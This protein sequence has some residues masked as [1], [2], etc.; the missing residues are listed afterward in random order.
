MPV[1]QFDDIPQIRRLGRRLLPE[2]VRSGLGHDHFGLEPHP[3]GRPLTDMMQQRSDVPGPAGFVP[4]G[5][6]RVHER[7]VGERA[8]ESDGVEQIRLAHSVRAGDA[9][10][11]AE[12]DIHG[13]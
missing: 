12:V 8:Q 3:V 4:N 7:P 13:Y 5:L 10:E 2:F 9:R 1:A 11:R 6:G